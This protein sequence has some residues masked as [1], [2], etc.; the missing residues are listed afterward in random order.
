MQ[1]QTPELAGS[2]K[3]I[4]FRPFSGHKQ[5]T[6]IQLQLVKDDVDLKT[7]WVYEI[8]CNCGKKYI[9]KIIYQVEKRCLDHEGCINL[10]QHTK[11]AMV[12]QTLKT[13]HKIDL[14]LTKQQAS[15]QHYK[16]AVS[17]RSS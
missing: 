2:N 14:N 4:R 10:K 11:S 3:N 1:S 15:G 17:V 6:E 9:G 7:S 12:E 13:G 5:N 16:E 8:P